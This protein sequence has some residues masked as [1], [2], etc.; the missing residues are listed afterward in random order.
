MEIIRRDSDYAFRCLA[1]LTDL[2]SDEKQV[3]RKIAESGGMPESLLRKVL[4]KLVHAGL[5]KSSKGVNGGFCLA[6]APE[7]IS[8]SM[9]L[10]AVQGPVRLNRCLGQGQLCQRQ[11][12]CGLHVGLLG[13]QNQIDQVLDGTTLADI[14][15]T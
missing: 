5:V 13:I 4:Q 9:V 15:K 3:V 6:R 1:Q 7:E 2:G 10:E 11:S 14:L 8:V 12:T